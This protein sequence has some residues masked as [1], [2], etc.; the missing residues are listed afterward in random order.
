[1]KLLHSKRSAAAVAA[2][3]VAGLMLAGC[4][5]SGHASSASG[6]SAPVR[7]GTL[8]VG[9][10]NDAVPGFVLAGNQSNWSWERS[11]FQTLA[12]LDAKGVPRPI[13]AKSWKVAANGLSIDVKLRDDV[14]FSTGRKMTADDVKAS[15]LDALNPAFGSQLAFI[16]KQFT[17]ITVQSPTE[18]TIDFAAPLPNIFDFFELTSI[19]DPTTVSGLANGS[20]V[21]G[22]GPYAWQSWTPAVR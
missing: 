6:S 1:M 18:L 21:I 15:F 7:G 13:L 16:A 8:T 10:G 19:I 14:T 20:K 22:T 9:S 17:A 5:P 3:V 11:V 4:T 2:V 12:S